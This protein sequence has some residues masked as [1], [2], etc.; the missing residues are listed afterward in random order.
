MT[1]LLTEED[2]RV[3]V[4]SS[5]DLAETC[6]NEQTADTQCRRCDAAMKAVADAEHDAHIRA[7]W[8]SAE[9]IALITKGSAERELRQYEQSSQESGA[10]KG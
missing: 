1:H 6:R 4:C 2:M 5:C 8:K 7:G 3:G 9:E 10:K